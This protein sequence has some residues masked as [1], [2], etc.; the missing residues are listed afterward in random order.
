[1]ALISTGTGADK[2]AAGTTV[3]RP[4]ATLSDAGL[5][6]FNSDLLQLEQWDGTQWGSIGGGVEVG[7][8]PPTIVQNGDLWYNSNDGRLYV[9]YTDANSSQ[10]VDASPDNTAESGGGANVAV[11]D[12]PPGVPEEGDLWYSTGGAGAGRLY[13]YYQDGSSNQWVDVSPSEELDV[14]GFVSKSGDNMTGNLTLATNAITLET[15]GR[16]TF[17]SGNILLNADGSSVFKGSYMD[18]GDGLY[19]NP[20][21]GG[22]FIWGNDATSSGGGFFVYKS[23]LDTVNINSSALTVLSA[24]DASSTK[25]ARFQ[26]RADGSVVIGTDTNDT[27]ST[28][29]TLGADGSGTFKNNILVSESAWANDSNPG[30]IVDVFTGGTAQAIK[31]PSSYTGDVFSIFRN[32]LGQAYGAFTINADGT[33]KIGGTQPTSPNIALNANGTSVFQ[34]TL[35]IENAGVGQIALNTTPTGGDIY[36]RNSN[37]DIQIDINGAGDVSGNVSFIHVGGTGL[38]TTSVVPNAE[39]NADGSSVYRFTPGGPTG[40]S[41]ALT[42]EQTAVTGGASFRSSNAAA[43]SNGTWHF[44]GDA[45]STAFSGLGN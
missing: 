45:N 24:A 15:G 5:I 27:A 32:G 42:I 34:S 2:L 21:T 11:S 31:N 36:C 20:G 28:N 41:H 1:M 17:G 38:A 14:S 25:T 18:I 35:T 44:Y 8:I 9:Y 12:S 26:A 29:I 10:W 13:V 3:Q 39:I 4:T 37:G 40:A 19:Q 43:G 22:T 16:G 33:T 7:D 23:T 6:R 30:V